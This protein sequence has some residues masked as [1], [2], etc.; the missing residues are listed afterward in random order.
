M[1]R[2]TFVFLPNF[3]IKLD[4]LSY[5]DKTQ[6]SFNVNFALVVNV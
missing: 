4:Y 3:R 6:I 1:T 2:F 5:N